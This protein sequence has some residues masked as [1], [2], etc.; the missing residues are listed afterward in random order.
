M[1]G[2]VN[3]IQKTVLVVY[4]AEKLGHLISVYHLVEIEA[5]EITIGMILRAVRVRKL[6][7]VLRREFSAKSEVEP[8]SF[9]KNPNDPPKTHDQLMDE[10]G[11][12]K[13]HSRSNSDGSVVSNAL[14]KV[15]IALLLVSLALLAQSQQETIERLQKENSSTHVTLHKVLINY[16]N[17]IEKLSRENTT[18]NQK[19]VLQNELQT[20]KL[21]VHIALLRKELMEKTGQDDVDMDK[22]MREFS[23]NVRNSTRNSQPVLWLKED[24]ELKDYLPNVNEYERKA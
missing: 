24:S 12:S 13:N 17:Q 10:Y 20:W 4:R 14:V 16:K 9:F 11:S 3:F 18:R 6:S 23:K 5:I 21:L 22:V 8:P 19:L 1:D 15:G 7:S 2:R